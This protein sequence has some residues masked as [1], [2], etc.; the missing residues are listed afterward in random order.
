MCANFGISW[1]GVDH[2]LTE[3]YDRITILASWV[4]AFPP[5]EE[6]GA[7]CSPIQAVS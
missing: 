1:D 2:P 5:F 4:R 6:R 7:Y 3:Y